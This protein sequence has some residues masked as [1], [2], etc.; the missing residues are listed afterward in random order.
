MKTTLINLFVIF[1]LLK[2]FQGFSQDQSQ[3]IREIIRRANEKLLETSKLEI[4]YSWHQKPLFYP[5]F[6]SSK[7]HLFLDRS[8][9]NDDSLASFITFYDSWFQYFFNNEFCGLSNDSSIICETRDTI[10]KLTNNDLLGSGMRVFRSFIKYPPFK[11]SEEN[12]QYYSLGESVINNIP[13]HRIFYVRS[14]EEA[15]YD[16]TSFD[17]SKKD[18]TFL[19]FKDVLFENESQDLQ[20]KLFDSISYKSSETMDLLSIRDSI[21]KGKSIKYYDPYAAE[22]ANV[23]DTSAF[24]P[25]YELVDLNKKPF[26]I[27][28]LKTKYALVDFSYTSCFYCI[29]SIPSMKKIYDHFGKQISMIMFNPNDIDRKNYSDSVFRSRGLNYPIYFFDRKNSKLKLMVNA[30]PTVYLI[31]LST[32]KILERYVGYTEE[33]EKKITDDLEKL[34][35]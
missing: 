18:Y 5:K 34:V 9:L 22:E 10:Q 31:E 16:S 33:L 24:L 4:T 28:S 1:I 35:H 29:K 19:Q 14:Y 8:I 2:S 20:I 17:F 11:I 13:C 12:I 6:Y 27:A 21:T 3:Q 7:V 32:M 25:S 26:S 23:S 15:K 30:F